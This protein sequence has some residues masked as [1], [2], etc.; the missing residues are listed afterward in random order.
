MK[1]KYIEMNSSAAREP[2]HG[3]CCGIRERS[4]AFFG[5]LGG[6]VHGLTPLTALTDGI[7]AFYSS[8]SSAFPAFISAKHT[9][10]RCRRCSLDPVKPSK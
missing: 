8:E 7:I 2:N 1:L 6:E 4:R 3:D 9:D 5:F 10:R